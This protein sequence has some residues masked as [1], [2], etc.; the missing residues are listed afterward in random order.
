MMQKKNMTPGEVVDL[1]GLVM[2]VNTLGFDHVVRRHKIS[3]PT[4]K[5]RLRKLGKFLGVDLID[6]AG[7]PTRYLDLLARHGD[8]VQRQYD[9]ML[10]TIDRAKADAAE[11]SL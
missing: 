5:A 8:V 6:K 4:A 3:V 9:R 11:V 2:T 7:K 1:L 10:S